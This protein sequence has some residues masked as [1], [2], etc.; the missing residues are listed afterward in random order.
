LTLGQGFPLVTG[1]FAGRGALV[2]ICGSSLLRG[3]YNLSA[4]DVWKD[5][6]EG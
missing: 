6:Y 2:G 1:S 5:G 3:Q 4:L